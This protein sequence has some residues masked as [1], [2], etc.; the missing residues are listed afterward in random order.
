VKNETMGDKTLGGG[1]NN[2]VCLEDEKRKTIG[3]KNKT[4]LEKT[5]SR[6]LISQHTG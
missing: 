4:K 6:M 2:S 5:E 1:E 3:A